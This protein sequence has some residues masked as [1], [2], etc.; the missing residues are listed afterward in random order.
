[1]TTH[2]SAFSRETESTWKESKIYCKESADLTMR[3]DRSQCLQAGDPGA[4]MLQLQ[5]E[6]AGLG[7]RSAAP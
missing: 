7:A 5:P 4:L 1:M 6:L 3:A 2:Q